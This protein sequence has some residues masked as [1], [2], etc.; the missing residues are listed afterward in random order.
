MQIEFGLQTAHNKTLELINRGHTYETFEE[1][2]IKAKIGV[3]IE[4]GLFKTRVYK[5]LD[6]DSILNAYPLENIK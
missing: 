1:A 5:K 4:D 3:R 6:K 2:Y